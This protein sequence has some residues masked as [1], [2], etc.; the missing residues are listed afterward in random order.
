MHRI[1]YMKIPENVYLT[2][3]VPFIFGG[4]YIILYNKLTW[5]HTTYINRN[6]C[7]LPC[8]LSYAWHHVTFLITYKRVHPKVIC[9][10]K[11]YISTYQES[12]ST[13]KKSKSLWKIP[14]TAHQITYIPD[15]FKPNQKTITSV[16]NTM[17]QWWSHNLFLW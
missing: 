11:I 16:T 8:N 6:I 2:K 5:V 17:R 14:V 1:N 13:W 9:Q 15:K 7:I 12:G 10:V 3:G 4:V